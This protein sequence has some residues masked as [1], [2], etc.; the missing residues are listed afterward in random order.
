VDKILEA[1]RIV[2]ENNVFSYGYACWK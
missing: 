1:I 2:L